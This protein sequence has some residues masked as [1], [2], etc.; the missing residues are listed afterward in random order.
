MDPRIEPYVDICKQ[1]GRTLLTEAEA[2][3]LLAAF[4]IPTVDEEVATDSEIAVEH[5]ESL[6][7]PVVLKGLS[8][9]IPHKSEAGIIELDVE[10]QEEIQEGFKR[11]RENMNSYAPGARF[12]GVLVQPYTTGE[13]TILGMDLDR[14]FGPVILFGLG[15]VFVEIFDDATLRLPP[16]DREEAKSMIDDFQGEPLLTGTRG[17]TPRDVDVLVDTITTF[18]EFVEAAD[19]YVSEVDINPLMVH[20]QG[21]GVVAVDGLVRL[22]E[23]IYD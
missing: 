2:K 1:E 5:A 20:D 13:E 12:D 22:S 23:T 8:P 7:Y 16:L 9:D 10:S 21:D 11:I 14:Q 17:E 4:D 19:P 3:E 6:G 15:G 18:S